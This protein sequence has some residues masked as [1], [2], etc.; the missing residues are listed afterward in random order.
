MKIIS[1]HYCCMH[2][3]KDSIKIVDKLSLPNA[4][5]D[6]KHQ[7]DYKELN[8]RVTQSS[9]HEDYTQF[10]SSFYNSITLMSRD[11][12]VLFRTLTLLCWEVYYGNI[13]QTWP[14]IQMLI[15]MLKGNQNNQ[16]V[17]HPLRSQSVS[18]PVY[19]KLNVS[20]HIIHSSHSRMI[21]PAQHPTSSLA[22]SLRLC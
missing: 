17:N 7:A 9:W 19:D 18:Q 13:R 22:L 10:I 20:L 3:A 4:S 15:Q 14:V 1:R 2:K 6:N 21:K 8:E 5:V 11:E 12:A 16:L